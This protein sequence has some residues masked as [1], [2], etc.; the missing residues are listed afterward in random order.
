MSNGKEEYAALAHALREVFPAADYGSDERTTRTWNKCFEELEG[1]LKRNDTHFDSSEFFGPHGVDWGSPHPAKRISRN[2]QRVLVLLAAIVVL[3]ALWAWHRNGVKEA[4]AVGRSDTW[5]LI[6]EKH[7]GLAQRL[8][9]YDDM[10]PVV[11]GPPLR[12]KDLEHHFSQYP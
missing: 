7:L 1:V 3:T 11:D 10:N 8:L 4:R 6:C 12:C 5:A 9:D 2:D